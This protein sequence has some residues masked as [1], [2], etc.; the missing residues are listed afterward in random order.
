M[1][2]YAFGVDIGGTTVKIGLFETNGELSQKWEIPT[3]KEGNGSKILPDIAASLNDKLKEL[4]IPKE[5]VAGVGIDVP[6]PILDDEIVNRCVNLGWGVFN[7]AEKVRKLTGLDK[8]KVANDANAAALGEMWQGGG[9]SHQN[10]VMVTLGTGVGGGIISEGKIVA[11]AFGAS[12]EIGHML[13]NNDETQLCGCGKKSHLEQYASATG[14]ARKAKELLA[15]SSEESSLRGVDQLDA[16][17]VFDAAKE[18]DK[19]ALEIVDFV[20]ETLGTALASISCVFDPEV[21]VIGGGVSKAGQILLDTVQKHFV[22]AAFHASG[23]T[24]F[25]LAQLGND[26]GMYGAVKMV[27]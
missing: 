14:I 19:L 9:E 23:G 22:D 4:D 3:R 26:A 24:E 15:E 8:V 27:L 16:K 13:V 2:K 11:G 17:A 5:E 21:Y 12:G 20:G 1:K 10:V 6:G 25:A 18:G 7:V